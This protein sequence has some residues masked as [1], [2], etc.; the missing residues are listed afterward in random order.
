MRTGN[1]AKQT[2]VD[3]SA[4]SVA[5]PD[6][7]WTFGRSRSWNGEVSAPAPGSGSALVGSR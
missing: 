6:G 4:T 1:G 7:A 5:E 3:Q 2:L